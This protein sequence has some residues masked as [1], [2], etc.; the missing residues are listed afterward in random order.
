VRGRTVFAVFFA[1]AS[2]ATVAIYAISTIGIFD[3]I[4]RNSN[5]GWNAYQVQA[6]LKAQP[7]YPTWD[8]P[9]VNNY[10]PLSFYV[11]AAL[12]LATHDVIVSGR[13]IS[14]LGILATGF[15]VGAI[16]AVLT[17]SKLNGLVAALFFLMA[18]GVWFQTY[19]AMNDPQWLGHGVQTT[20]AL[21]LLADVRERRSLALVVLGAALMFLGCAV[22]HNLVVL[23]LTVWGVLFITDRKAWLVMTLAFLVLGCALILFAFAMYGRPFFEQILDYQRATRFVRGVRYL[24]N[25][26]FVVVPVLVF[27]LLNLALSPGGWRS[28]FPSVYALCA[29]LIGGFALFG[30]GINC[31]ALF[32]AVIAMALAV[33]SLFEVL[34]GL[35]E[36]GGVNPAISSTLCALLLFSPV[37][38]SLN[39]L[40]AP[41]EAVLTRPADLPLARSIVDAL[42]NANGRVACEISAWCFWANKPNVYDVFAM[43]ER[44]KRGGKEETRF[45]EEVA[46]AHY[47]AIETQ[48]NARITEQKKRAYWDA[49]IRNYVLVIAEPSE[50]WVRKTPDGQSPQASS[51]VRDHQPQ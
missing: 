15:N 34:P 2:A 7:L 12:S 35:L 39:E 40:I 37:L 45:V 13:V 29:C 16:S 17:R 47:A 46:N 28:R 31:N 38:A 44:A 48:S 10:P 5:E 4:P 51:A 18:A 8:Q 1:A 27:A 33:G 23:P 24:S 49:L 42:A 20:G 36:S 14:L 30:E 22:K 25:F 43:A 21:I 32:D 11:V 50:V 41:G 6:I 26:A 19:V 9:R 3:H